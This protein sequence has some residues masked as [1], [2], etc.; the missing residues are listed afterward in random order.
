MPCARRDP[1]AAAAAAAAAAATVASVPVVVRMRLA[2]AVVV[3]LAVA[4]SGCTTGNAPGSASSSALAGSTTSSAG[5][6]AGAATGGSGTGSS[7]AMDQAALDQALRSAAW[8]NDVAGARRLIS[9]GADVNAKDD[10]VQSA[11]LIATSEGYDELLAL[12]LH[13]GAKVNDKDSWNGTGLIRAAE[14]GHYLVVGRLL[15]AGIDKDHVNR[16]GYQALHEAVWLG[17]DQPAE[18]ATVNVLIAGGV[19]LDRP[20]GSER[21]TPLEMARQRG[22]RSLERALARAASHPS[23]TTAA[24]VALEELEAAVTSGDATAAALALRDGAGESLDATARRTLL[25]R[26]T[27]GG[28][29]DL[30]RLLQAH[31]VLR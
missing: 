30:I 26:A 23:S 27:A 6:P 16:I 19:Q 15:A 29:D 17:A 31:F 18:L 1:L 8:A 25:D 14:R 3:G 24:T 22:Y 20:S 2:V 9:Q 13:S 12:T 5:A 11:Y 21:L 4:L 10:T 7:D 28:H